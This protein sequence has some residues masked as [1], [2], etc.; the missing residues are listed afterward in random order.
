[1][2]FRAAL[3]ACGGSQ[4]SG[5]IRAVAAGLRR[6]H[7][8]ATSE[9]RLRPTP[10]LMLGSLAE[11]MGNQWCMQTWCSTKV[12]CLCHLSYVLVD[13]WTQRHNKSSILPRFSVCFSVSLACPTCM[14]SLRMSQGCMKS[15]FF[16]AFYTFLTSKIPHWN[17]CVFCH[18]TW[19]E[20]VN[21]KW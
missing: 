12:S 18:L 5:L 10:Q 1:M 2:A 3:E 11:F 14:C 15:L 9:P 4:A 13:K 8:N 19:T 7:S 17:F 20:F 6:N 16:Q 21:A